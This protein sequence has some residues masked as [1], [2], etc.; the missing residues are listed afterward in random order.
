MALINESILEKNQVRM[1]AERVQ[2]EIKR[3]RV[4]RQCFNFFD[5]IDVNNN[6]VLPIEELSSQ[7]DNIA[8]V[9]ERN[10][11]IY[12][13]SD[14]HTMFR[15]MDVNDTGMIDR[16]EFVQ[17]IVDLSDQIRPMSIMEL[18]YQVSK[19]A[20]RVEHI[21]KNARSL[22]K[23]L[24]NYDLHIGK[25]QGGVGQMQEHWMKTDHEA[26]MV[27]EVACDTSTPTE[28]MLLDLD[29]ARLF[30]VLPLPLPQP[31]P[32]GDARF[33]TSSMRPESARTFTCGD[34][35]SYPGFDVFLE[36]DFCNTVTTH[37]SHIAKAEA[38]VSALLEGWVSNHNAAL[39][40]D[41]AVIVGEIL[42]VQRSA[43]EV[44]DSIASHELRTEVN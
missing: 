1:E 22:C 26:S 35:R 30:P 4:Q 28:P 23:S 39:S 14:L 9:L 12:Q 24:D 21:D 36:P 10:G 25:L 2:R 38:Q 8:S 43:V 17:A 40:S 3:R 33:K 20:A 19:C 5:S 34:D 7:V 6:R 27:T 32:G 37:C 29:N 13:L 42:A 41:L 11:V 15:I 16:S 44:L 18:H 31:P